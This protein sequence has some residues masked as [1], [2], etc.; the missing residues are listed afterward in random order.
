MMYTVCLQERGKKAVG[1]T[2]ATAGNEER[3]REKGKGQP[4]PRENRV[5]QG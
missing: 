4:V 3:Q 5:G 2:K 1:N